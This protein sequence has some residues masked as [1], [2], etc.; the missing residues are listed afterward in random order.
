M[1]FVQG[2]L[3]LE[4]I[5]SR[6]IR[7]TPARLATWSTCPRRYRM[8]YVD[9]PTPSR[10][11]PWA[12]ST[13]GAVVHNV[14]RVL[15]ELPGPRRTT[16]RAAALLREYWKNDGFAGPE[17]AADY[18]RRAQRWLTDYLEHVDDGDAPVAVERWVSAQV[19]TII[20]EGRAD[21]IDQRGRELVIVDYKTGR[22]APSDEDAR[23]SA[24]LA[25]YAVAARSTLRRECRRVELHH[26]PTASVGTWEHDETSLDAH[27]TRAEELA[28]Q[29]RTATEAVGDRP[30]A[31]RT[32]AETAAAE[33]EFPARPGPHCASCDF[34]RHCPEG[35]RAAPENEPWALLGE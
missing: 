13:L 4:G 15:F 3:E 11:G 29:L 5:P 21:R 8:A 1:G 23:D 22:H 31:E 34:R 16:D 33:R 14:L 25:V 26:V 32:P 24:A 27:M 28:G 18:R 20:A 30:V 12:H 19:G 10:H 7:V 9:R 2:Q 35:Q 6:L 17:Q